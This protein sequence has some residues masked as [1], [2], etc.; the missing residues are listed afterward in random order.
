M[1]RVRSIE[2][3]GR[4][5]GEVVTHI[6]NS[7]NRILV[8]RKTYLK[9][10][11]FL[12]GIRLLFVLPLLSS[13]FYLML[14]RLNITNLTDQTV[15]LFFKSPVALLLLAIW[16]LLIVYFI[17]YELGFYFLLGIRQRKG[18]DVSFKSLT[19][20]LLKKARYFFST[21]LLIIGSYFLLVLPL[22]SLGFKSELLKSIKVPDFI[23]DE[24][25]LTTKGKYLWF[26]VLFVLAY[27]S[28]RLLY[29]VYYFVEESSR[30]LGE[31]IS[32][33]WKRSKHKFL[34]NMMT[35][36]LVAAVVSI[37]SL[38]AVLVISLP[39]FVSD[40]LKPSLSPYVAGGVLTLMQLLL[41]FGGGLIQ[42]LIVNVVI[43]TII[44]KESEP[45]E[46][47]GTSVKTKAILVITGGLLFIALS[48]VNMWSIT[49]LIYQPQTTL[50]AHRGLMKGGIENSIGSL[51]AAASS[52]VEMVEMD[53]Q[54][55]KDGKFVVYHDTNLKRLTGVSKNTYDLTLEELISYEMKQS[56]F[57][58]TISDLGT[59]ID[60]AKE[61]GINLLVEV[62]PHGKESKEM[63]DNLINLLEEKK[64]AT[65]YIV[66][67]L[68]KDVLDEIKAKA[69][70]IK[71]GYVIP[72]T[73]GHAPKSDHDI[74]VIEEFSVNEKLISEI[75]ELDKEIFIWTVNKED[76]LKKYLNLNVDGIISNNADLGVGIR[77][78]L[79]EEK[80]LYERVILMLE[81]M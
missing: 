67:S 70:Y 21:H 39:L 50:I 44:G 53:I 74:Y 76:L 42:A 26:I 22:A 31:A 73:I 45:L 2:W 79:E 81:N 55:S 15:T 57:T 36:L 71:T 72:L 47:D 11:I 52:G 23:V 6:K 19:V 75:E 25:L 63:V 1:V 49:T 3:R 34:K 12:Q 5:I 68:D 48:S 56:G 37:V 60:R 27:L 28:M 10:T 66:Q 33:S 13:L 8:H 62:K 30:T 35:L 54:E 7:I 16:F 51:E 18:Q 64:V 20:E 61:L 59:Y 78:D 38:I 32:L 29:V 80:P 65:D 58:E 24:L 14:N 40:V 77:S 46:K 4:L 9:S 41:F 43:E 17:F 69:P